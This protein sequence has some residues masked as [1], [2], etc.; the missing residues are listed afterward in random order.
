MSKTGTVPRERSETGLSPLSRSAWAAVLLLA[1]A[2][3]AAWAGEAPTLSVYQTDLAAFFAE[4][5]AAYP[6]FDLKKNR[7]EWD[8]AK[9]RLAEEAKSCTSDSA[10]LGLVVESFRSLHDGHMGL[11]DAKA[12]IPP[13]PKKY[14]PGLSFMRA[15]KGRIVIMSASDTYAGRLDPGTVVTKIDGEDARVHLDERAEAAWARSLSSSPQRTCLYEYRIPFRGKQGDTHTITYIAKGKERTLEVTCDQEARGWPHTYNLPKDLTRV[16]RSFH[17]TLLEDGAAYVYLR[18]IDTSAAAG[19]EKTRAAYPNAR[20][21]IVDLRGNGG[22]GYGADLINQFKALPRPVAVIIDAGCV[23][24]G[25]TVARDLA[26]HAEA[27]LFGSTTAGSSSSKRTWAFPSGIASIT[28]ST[29][30]R[31]RN[32]GEPIEFN[33]IVPDV[34]VE[35]TPEEVAL[36]WN[37]ALLRAKEYLREAGAAKAE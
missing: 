32:D 23:S 8:A 30:S 19:F 24:A 15:T 31:W 1:V 11:R 18:R 35:C 14:F 12:E 13:Q 5:D 28:M 37:S 9:A 2:T 21:W 33:G 20:G 17:H 16:G 4:V 36:G 22:G 6:F 29:R 10:F 7:A 26:R 3:A 34:L 27:R 25:E